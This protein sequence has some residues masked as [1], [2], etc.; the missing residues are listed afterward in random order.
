M[1]RRQS[2]M[3][4]AKPMRGWSSRSVRVTSGTATSRLKI[5][6]F[7][8]LQIT[9]AGSLV[10]GVDTP[11]L[12]SL[13]AWLLL[14]ADVPQPKERVASLLWPDSSGP[15][16]RTNLRQLLHHLKRA[17]P[18][19]NDLLRADHFSVQWERDASCTIDVVEFQA[20]LAEA[21]KAFER[22]DRQAES[23]WLKK[24][25]NI[26]TD[27]LL[28]V[29]YDEWLVPIRQDLHAQ[30][31]TALH[32][33]ASLLETFGDVRS[34]IAC[35]DKLV[36]Q[37]VT[38]ESSY[39]LLMRLHIANGDRAS[40]V[41]T[42]HQC[43][44]VLR[45]ELGIQ[46]GPHTIALF[47][48]VLKTKITDPTLPSVL[49]PEQEKTPLLIGRAQDMQVLQRAWTSVRSG[50]ALA[51]IISGEPGIGK[52]RL[53]DEFLQQVEDGGYAV[54]RSRC[55]FG[56]GQVAYAPVAMWLR[57]EPLR[58]AWPSLSVAQR[59]E[60]SRLVPEISEGTSGTP[61]GGTASDSWHKKNLYGALADA[62]TKT[63]GPL[64]LFLDDLQW[65]DS[66]SL[67]WLQVFLS[68]GAAKNMLVLGTVREEE[69]DRDHPFTNFVT[70]LRQVSA[71]FQV[72]LQP[73]D[74][75]CTMMLAHRESTEPLTAERNT[76][77]YDFTKGNPLF[78]VES[79]RAGM[80][81]T[82][83]QAVISA[84]LARLSAAAHE[85]AG[86]ASIVG[87]T[88][89]FE[90]LER[91]SDW[92]ERS[93]SQALDELWQR[94]IIQC[95]GR[96]EYDF[97]HDRLREVA[98]RELSPVR[99]RYLHRRVAR[100]LSEV[101]SGDIQEW[102]GQIA[103]HF[104]Q[105][106]MV[107]QAIDHLCS[108]AD[109][110]RHRFA[111]T[112]SAQLLRRALT[113]LRQF[114]ES[115]KSF[116]QELKILALLGTALVTTAGYSAAEVGK[117]DGRALQIA[118]HLGS[119]KLFAILSG[120]WVFHVVGGHIETSRQE[121][122]E[123]LDAAERTSSSELKLAGNFLLGSSLSHLGQF[124]SS[125]EHLKLALDI[126]EASSA[127]VLEVFGGPD[128][129]VFC[130]AYLSHVAWHRASDAADRSAA[131]FIAEAVQAAEDMNHPFIQ[132]IAL[133]YNTMLHAL[134][135]DSAA[136][137]VVGRRTIE[138]CSRHAF[139]YYLAMARVLTAW[140]M[141]ATGDSAHGLEQFHQG[142]DAMRELGA[143]LRLPFYY[144]LLSQSYRQVGMPRE[145]S[146]SLA[147]GFAFA[148][149]NGEEWANSEL[150]R[151]QG[152]LLKD[153]CLPDQAVANYKRALDAA[154]R[155]G[156]LAFGRRLMTLIEVISQETP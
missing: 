144:A 27:D 91:A 125:F 60:L 106:G 98:S 11:R 156:S 92:D 147:T 16:A 141:C 9:A 133:N 59:A 112:E 55:H 137:L 78:V 19:S 7:G 77:L 93:L 111:Y 153:Q 114:P 29:V 23:A 86:L 80:Q 62:F 68:A 138:L 12:H 28:P 30:L 72:A 124:R 53:A 67:E 35:V 150:Y 116:D 94:R 152:D 95:H 36:A 103:F 128:V 148:S 79:I 117:T 56:Q 74:K 97:T 10:T 142:L 100:A 105:A 134:E 40:A 47:Q 45:R 70:F 83:I 85:L 1:Y 51:V 2:E 88:F 73:L 66:E 6:L 17:L 143:E 118:R 89:S 109:F 108:A 38:A 46:P 4:L 33:S 132:A 8:N 50:G 81:S 145:A 136:A 61:E 43:K 76:E 69:T 129:R 96:A 127:S 64:L 32:R 102:N 49:S 135:G 71:I 104:E 84:R 120:S 21:A 15:Q 113:L 82:R 42:Y 31:S 140:A 24:A 101:Y 130:R 22:Q 139:A 37:D 146:A 52:T 41:R 110:A 57:A 34:A 63:A 126:H 58:T 65:C 44:V 151:A 99:S 18:A 39:Q 149:K 25:I 155:C 54:A 131:T 154:K 115:E 48:I 75:A 14:Q 20:A 3:R 119:H 107:E 13:L 122:L 5:K 26:Y 90:L 87:N 121:A 123:F